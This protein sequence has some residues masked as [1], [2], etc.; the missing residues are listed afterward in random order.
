MKKALFLKRAFLVV[1]SSLLASTYT[2][3]IR[4][5][6]TADPNSYAQRSCRLFGEPL[7][8]AD[9][10]D[11]FDE[12]GKWKHI[13]SPATREGVRGNFE[14]Y[15]IK[16][17]L[18]EQDVV[19]N[20][21]SPFKEYESPKRQAETSINEPGTRYSKVR[22]DGYGSEPI[23]FLNLGSSGPPVFPQIVPEATFY[24][25][26][27]NVK[28]LKAQDGSG[29]NRRNPPWQMLGFLDAVKV[30]FNKQIEET[31]ERLNNNNP[32]SDF[33]LHPDTRP[34]MFFLQTASSRLDQS[35][36]NQA[37]SEGV[38]LYRHVICENPG[39]TLGVD[40][41]IMGSGVL[42]NKE[43]LTFELI[44]SDDTAAGR[45]PGTLVEV[46]NP[47]DGSSGENS[48]GSSNE[49][50]DESS[51]GS[52]SDSSNGSGD[53][54]N[55]DGSGDSGNGDGSGDSGNDSVFVRVGEIPFTGGQCS[56]VNYDITVQT[57]TNGQ[58]SPPRTTGV[59]TYSSIPGPIGLIYGLST[60]G[61]G[62]SAEDPGEFYKLTHAPRYV[63]VGL[64]TVYDTET[65]LNGSSN[66]EVFD[67]ELAILDVSRSDG[68]PDNCGNPPIL[69]TIID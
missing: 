10:Q 7:T 30:Q 16:H 12:A 61:H 34:R 58:P 45:A 33:V 42:V 24:E 51:D 5:K 23:L 20:D 13:P 56:G 28:R 11:G 52:G 37:T 44:V 9:L 27:T 62:Q 31:V 2:L 67:I 38:E 15:S 4:S 6:A 17:A 55:G 49:D 66:I 69:T 60:N 68:Q 22:P 41:V 14:A 54:G 59:R 35:Y 47:P 48:S 18:F 63:S 64:G 25:A 36:I 32:G 65:V 53:S 8:T 19:S 3:S 43:E 26:K 39:G 50:S 21:V 46:I 1:F 40:D 29:G 57:F